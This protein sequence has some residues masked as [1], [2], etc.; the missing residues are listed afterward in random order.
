VSIEEASVELVGAAAHETLAAIDPN[1]VAQSVQVQ[2]LGSFG[3]TCDGA[4]VESELLKR[5]H[6]RGLLA[7]LAATPE[8]AV[9]RSLACA[10]LWPEFDEARAFNRLYHTVLLLKRLLSECAGAGWWVEVRKGVIELAPAV[11]SDSIELLFAAGGDADA[12]QAAAIAARWGR[13]PALAPWLVGTAIE[14]RRE[15]LRSAWRQLL[16]RLLRQLQGEG[17]TSRRR[18]ILEVCLEELPTDEEACRQ[19]MQLELRAGRPIAALEIF[20]RCARALREGLGLKPGPILRGLAASAVALL[21]QRPS[22]LQADTGGSI[23]ASLP[24]IGREELLTELAETLLDEQACIVALHGPGGVGKSRLAREIVRRHADSF[25]D[26]TFWIDAGSVPSLQELPLH[27]LAAA[28]V[29]NAERRPALDQLKE[30]LR[31]SRLLVVIDSAEALVD[32]PALLDAL[33]PSARWSAR[34]LVTSRLPLV[35]SSVKCVEIPCLDLPQPGTKVETAA[36]QLFVS[37]AGSIAAASIEVG[38]LSDIGRLVRRLDG[39]PLAIE[40]AAARCDTRTPAEVEVE[41]T[42]SLDVL[43]GG[44]LDLIE[45]HRSMAATL[46]WTYGLLSPSARRAYLAAGTFAE[47]FSASD[48]DQLCHVSSLSID[49]A[50]DLDELCRFRLVRQDMQIDGVRS[51]FSMLELPRLYARTLASQF[52]CKQ[53]LQAAHLA[54]VCG[55]ASAALKQS[56]RRAADAADRLDLVL[57]DIRSAVT[58]ALANDPSLAA[59][60]I[61]D[62]V[63]YLHLRGYLDEGI[64]YCQT[65]QLLGAACTTPQVLT[66]L[67][68]GVAAMMTSQFRFE[69]AVKI[70][71]AACAQS[72]TVSDPRLALAAHDVWLNLA[73]AT[74]RGLQALDRCRS[75]LAQSDPADVGINYW[76]LALRV[77]IATRTLRLPSD[78]SQAHLDPTSLRADLEGSQTWMLVLVS[79]WGARVEAED[80]QAAIDAADEGVRLASALQSPHWVA[81]FLGRRA[82]AELG[83]GRRDAFWTSIAAARRT[84]QRMGLRVQAAGYALHEAYVAAHEGDLRYASD[85][86]AATEALFGS[87]GTPALL[88]GVHCIRGRAALKSGQLDQARAQYAFLFGH[89]DCVTQLEDIATLLRVAQFGVRLLIGMGDT[90]GARDLV[91]LSCAIDFRGRSLP[92]ERL[93]WEHIAAELGVAG[94]RAG[95]PLASSSAGS[96][97]A[98]LASALKS[99]AASIGEGDIA[100]RSPRSK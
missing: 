72:L 100:I 52:A 14:V 71:E 76:R 44:P 59:P 56:E 62:L 36:V 77:R 20:E 42:D 25:E 94:L 70:A 63:W 5:V 74:H 66:R 27:V 3:L 88:V 43:A 4:A 96:P 86:I 18:R 45:R 53:Q 54:W 75:L 69:E 84:A 24:I 19:L 46:Q 16:Q 50:R 8:R 80:Y 34:L 28:G 64:R 90:D 61:A 85:R 1:A 33:G 38:L 79:E 12:E 73:V 92:F 37:R 48:L 89:A 22:A 10:A 82:F 51:R 68:T 2:L 47:A 58:Y 35:G 13:L 81:E 97:C 98:T 40:L 39:L 55:L 6:V 93:D 26:G 83:A 91:R 95:H 9:E 31:D 99:L 23:T 49:V 67:T 32:L 15:R 29:V 21:E 7:L 11:T 30:L 65:A 17:D 60:L 41:L 78:E 87:R 57:P